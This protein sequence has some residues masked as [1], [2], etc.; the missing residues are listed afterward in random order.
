MSSSHTAV[1]TAISTT[2]LLTGLVPSSSTTSQNNSTVFQS[3]SSLETLS[4]LVTSSDFTVE[5]STQYLTISV[6]VSTPFPSASPSVLTSTFSLTIITSSVL[7]PNSTEAVNTV[8]DSAQLAATTSSISLNTTNLPH[9]HMIPFN[10]I[11]DSTQLTSI[12]S[13]ILSNPPQSHSSTAVMMSLTTVL[14]SH[15]V[16]SATTTAQNTAG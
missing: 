12:S 4:L 7:M 11:T 8:T 14:S 16:A 1:A 2:Q 6:K 5:S 3:F 9:S 13:S 15:F 10:T